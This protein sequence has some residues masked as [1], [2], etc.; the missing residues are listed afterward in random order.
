MSC[1][2]DAYKLFM[3]VWDINKIELV[4]QFHVMLLDWRNHCL[5]VSHIATGG[6]NYCPVETKHIYALAL[7]ARASKIQVA[8]N[9]PSGDLFA[10][11]QDQRVTDQ[12]REAGKCLTLPHVDHLLVNS[13]SYA[14]FAE[15][16][17]I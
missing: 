13:T 1:A 7:K 4:E 2:E 17:I 9:H 16:G 15:L 12:L 5:F 14:S 3:S 8:H 11:E 6:Y 10:S